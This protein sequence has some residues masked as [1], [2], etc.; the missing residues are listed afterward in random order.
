[1]Q[2]YLLKDQMCCV[3]FLQSQTNAAHTESQN[4]VMCMNKPCT[5][6]T[7]QVSSS[8]PADKRGGVS[9]GSPKRSG[10]VC[11]S[12]TGINHFIQFMELLY[13]IKTC[14]IVKSHEKLTLILSFTVTMMPHLLLSTSS[15]PP[16]AFFPLSLFQVEGATA[17]S[18]TA[19]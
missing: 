9:I 17:A 16:V 15:C 13:I 8:T 12:V 1:M 14:L 3:H 10:S 5:C 6:C 7:S 18:M 19:V 4:R 2:P 11:P